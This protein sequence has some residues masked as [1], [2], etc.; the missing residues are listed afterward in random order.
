MFGTKLSRSAI[1]VANIE[2]SSVSFS[3]VHVES[4]SGATIAVTRYAELPLEERTSG[5][6]LFAL[7]Q[8]LADIVKQA[9][10]DYNATKKARSVRK[11]YAIV[12]AP[13]AVGNLV[14]TAVSFPEETYISSAVIARCAEKAL[15]ARKG[16]AEYLDARQLPIMLNGYR[17]G[18]PEGKYAH[19][20]E[21]AALISTCQADVRKEISSTLQEAFPGAHLIIHSGTHAVLE[22]L[23]VARPHTSDAVC[24]HISGEGTEIVV[25][26]GGIA[27]DYAY[28]AEGLRTMLERAFPGMRPDEARTAVRLMQRQDGSDATSTKT[29]EALLK[30]EPDMAHAYG[31]GLAAISAKLRLPNALILI[32]DTD[33]APWLKKFFERIDF[34]QFTV[35]AQ[36]FAVDIISAQEFGSITGAEKSGDL[37]TAIAASHVMREEQR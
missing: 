4:A 35:T 30:A 16:N 31:E 26:R 21:V 8:R 29:E 10:A 32:A 15:G 7:K 3:I 34:S 33:I 19:L 20:L 37:D 2:S 13:W 23:E 1:G 12:H 28:V 11:L 9:L 25:V 14:Q 6:H 36:P 18:L 24:M 17:T 22:A 5:Q 27:V